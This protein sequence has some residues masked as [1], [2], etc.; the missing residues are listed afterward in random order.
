MSPTASGEPRRTDVRNACLCAAAVTAA[1]FA[2][3]PFVD[4]HFCDDPSYACIVREFLRTGRIIYNGG[5]N[6]IVLPHILWGALFVKIFGF[7]ATV[8]RFSTLPMAIGCAI[9]CYALARQA[10]LRPSLAIFTSLLLCLSPLFLPLATSFMTDVPGLFFIL[11]SLCA[12]IR[13][14]QAPPHRASLF[15]VIVGCILGA[16]GGLT[17]QIVWAVPLALLPYLCCLRRSNLA[18]ILAAAIL[19]IAIIVEAAVAIHWFNQQPYSVPE[20]PLRTSLVLGFY[21]WRYVFDQLAAI[22]FT[23]VLMTLPSTLFF[24]PTSLRTIWQQRRQASAIVTFLVAVAFGAVLVFHPQLT[25]EPYMGNIV[26]NTE[27]GMFFILASLCALIH[28]SKADSRFRS[29]AWLFLGCLLAAIGGLTRQIIWGVPLVLAPYLCCLRRRDPAF[30][31]IAAILWL[32][33]IVEAIISIH[34]FNH[35]PYILPEW[36][37]R[38]SFILAARSPGS[39]FV[40]L[41]L[42]VLTVVLMTLPAAIFFAPT[43]LIDLWRRRRSTSGAL[44]AVAAVTLC[45]ILLLNQKLAIEPY[46]GNVISTQGSMGELE[47]SGRRPDSQPVIVRE[48]LAACVTI[49][50][51]VVLSHLLQWL[52]RRHKT[53]QLVEFFFPRDGGAAL[54]VL[55]L[56]AV[57]YLVLLLPRAPFG[58]EFD[59]YIL[60]LM[61]IAVIFFLSRYQSMPRTRTARRWIGP[62]ACLLLALYALFG[63]ALTQDVLALGRARAN[64]VILLADQGVRPTAIAAGIERD[65]WTQASIEGYVNRFEIR[66]PPGAFHAEL[67]PFPVLKCEYRLEFQRQPDTIPSKFGSIDYISWLPPFHRRI[68]IDQFRNPWWLH[69]RPGMPPDPKQY[70]TFYFF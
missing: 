35:Q 10:T 23:I 20:W 58:L 6:A 15:W 11:A 39:V 36:P 70:E 64:A 29:V 37:I 5:A 8:L 22:L 56:F 44:S 65:A 16:I 55:V 38:S 14:A 32:L 41:A 28:C 42:I 1:F 59:R 30:I 61:P 2:V 18:F 45:G 3:N 54:P 17:R 26:S 25:I 19:W 12:L 63:I 60:P 49:V 50:C 21:W 48:L 67:G 7:S 62:A 51:F 24:L 31:A 4:S 52:V 68:Y 34:W 57:G 13:C 46:M 47:L 69:R 40:Q 53:R 9:L 33:I 43:A 27:P 66:N